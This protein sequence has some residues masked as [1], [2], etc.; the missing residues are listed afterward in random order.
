MYHIINTQ[1]VN[2]INIHSSEYYLLTTEVWFPLRLPT[3][4]KNPWK[5]SEQSWARSYPGRRWY[6][7]TEPK[8]NNKN[9][10]E[11]LEQS[12]PR[13]DPEEGYTP[14]Q[15]KL[16]LK[17][18][19]R[20]T[21]YFFTGLARIPLNTSNFW[22]LC[23]QTSKVESRDISTIQ[24]AAET[25][26]FQAMGR[27]RLER[28]SK[29]L[30]SCAGTCHWCFNS[31]YYCRTLVCSQHCDSLLPRKWNFVAREGLRI[32]FVFHFWSS[33]SWRWQ[34]PFDL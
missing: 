19:C 6:F 3:N 28:A 15:S 11:L 5:Y 29:K 2:S 14:E 26:R 20:G 32:P 16:V 30:A 1:V 18:Q 23:T 34:W 7:R 25:S 17:N 13:S 31:H 9:P 21:Y 24:S 12:W 22:K 8:T 27:M 10:W 33:I 4:N